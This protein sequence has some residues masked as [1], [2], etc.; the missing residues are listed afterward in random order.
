MSLLE[1]RG[2]IKSRNARKAEQGDA[3]DERH[4]IA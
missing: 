2:A 1:V 3:H 4:S